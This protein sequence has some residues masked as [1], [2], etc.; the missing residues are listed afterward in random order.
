MKNDTSDKYQKNGHKDFFGQFSGKEKDD[1][2]E[3]WELSSQ[4]ETS[5]IEV[6][7]QE[8]EQDLAAIQERLTKSKAPD[9]KWRWFAAA[10]VLMLVLA[11]GL[12]FVPQTVTAPRGEIVQT[13][14]PDGSVVELN[15]GSQLQYNR[16]FAFANRDVSLEGE[17]FFSVESGDHPFII[18]ANG[19]AVKVTGTQ[20]NVRSWDEDP[21]QKTEVAVTEG[22]VQFYPV[23]TPKRFVTIQKGEL[24]SWIGSLE[25]LT[26]PKPVE[27]EKRIGW[28]EH[29][30][31]FHEESLRTIFAELERRFNIT[32]ELKAQQLAD[33]T[34]TAFYNNPKEAAS[35]LKDICRVK[36]LRYAKT[37]DGY[38]VYK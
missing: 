29:K 27:V 34:L 22:E 3:M 31:L 8:I 36:G 30:L 14:L 25:E 33:E 26:T 15:S 24:S 19:S 35:V 17:A 18:E 10:A 9:I 23:N 4:A 16:L 38:R 28:R 7:D 5:T 6:S 21:D 13:T 2:K 37:V 20:F 1:L 11:A 32:I 12:L